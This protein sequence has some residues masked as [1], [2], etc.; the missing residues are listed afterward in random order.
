MSKSKDVGN[1]SCIGP[2]LSGKM[3][4]EFNLME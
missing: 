4:I 3:D 2:F 1:F